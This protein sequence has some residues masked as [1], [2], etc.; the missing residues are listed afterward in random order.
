MSLS[1]FQSSV[2]I[3]LTSVFPKSLSSLAEFCSGQVVGDPTYSIIGICS[4]EQQ[5]VNHLAFIGSD[6]LIRQIEPDT[7]CAYIVTP[8]Y[9]DKIETGIIHDNPTQA[10][11]LI[12]ESLITKAEPRIAKSAIIADKAVIGQSVTIGERVIIESGAI[13]GDHCVIHAGSV[14]KKNVKLGEKT[15]VGHQVTLHHDCTIGQACVLADGVVIGAQ[16]FGFS[17]EGGGWQAIPQIGKVII[18]DFVHIGANTCIDRGAIEDTVI[19]NHVIIDNL[20]H[21]AHNVKIG[22]GTAIAACVGIAGSTTVGK[23]CLLA[24]QVG[25]AGHLTLCDGVQV[26]GGAKVLQSIKT[27]GVYAGSFTALPAVKWNRIAVYI[28]K[29]ESL[30]KREK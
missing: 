2:L 15:V 22:T 16:G 26:N 28:K 10:Y 18:G 29:I 27:P 23:H 30:F 8:A 21:I 13:I 5:R 24:G 20:V 7:G 6:R 11:R 12:L 1:I 17:F 14:I 9:R 4:I 19:G 25:I 3:D